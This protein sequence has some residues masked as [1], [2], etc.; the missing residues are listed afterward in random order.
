LNLLPV[1]GSY[2]NSDMTEFEDLLALAKAGDAEAQCN[3][4]I[5]YA[6][7]RWV[8]PNQVEAS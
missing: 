3:P 5:M 1:S 2:T 4:G 7:G 8:R 6:N